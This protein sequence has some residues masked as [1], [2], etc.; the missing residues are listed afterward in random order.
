MEPK[1]SAG[2]WVFANPVDRFC[3]CGYGEPNTVIDQIEAA[4]K[5]PDL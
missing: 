2:L 1:F 4:A 3:P 5:V